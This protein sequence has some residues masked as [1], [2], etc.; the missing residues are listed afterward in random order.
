MI[1]TQPPVVN[2]S[3]QELSEKERRRRKMALDKLQ[4]Y[5]VD[6]PH[7][8]MEAKTVQLVLLREVLDY[9]VLRTEETRELNKVTT[10]LS[11]SQP[12]NELRVAFLASK[13]KAAESRQM[14]QVLRTAIKFAGLAYV[15]R[16][17]KP[18]LTDSPD[19]GDKSVDCYLKDNLCLSCPRCALYG[20]TSIEEGRGEPRA[21]IKHRIEY[22]T[23][24]SL[25]PF[26][27]IGESITFNALIDVT[28]TT[29]QALGDRYVVIP[30]T[31]FPSI[32]TLRSVT[33]REFVLAIKTLLACHSYGAESRTGGDARNTIFGIVAGWEEIITPLELTLELYD[34]RDS[35]TGDT[36]KTI[37]D[38]YKPLAGNKDRVTIFTP[39]EVEDLVK[40]AADVSL[41]KKFLE[42]S[43]KDMADYRKVQL[44]R[45]KK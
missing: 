3:S 36:I 26:K 32:V 28:Q 1:T 30:A 13:Q 18:T 8:L 23:A 6:K 37:L 21:N 4:P 19:K 44:E 29:G 33:R 7:P 9:T 25:M 10:P 24:F 2:V 11:I 42:E 14:E 43:Y 17:G 16:D 12:Q 41:D 39:Q 40:E 34:K 35:L 15:S 38:G 22:S 5:F 27:D 45:A 20:G 31:V